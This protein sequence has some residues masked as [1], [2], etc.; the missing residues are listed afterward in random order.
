MPNFTYLFIK[1]YQI[2]KFIF[3][4]ITLIISFN[5]NAQQTISVS[6]NIKTAEGKPLNKAS[7]SLYYYGIKDTLKTVTNEKG[8][9]VFNKVPTKNVS[10]AVSFIGYK[11][12]VDN[13]DL[14]KANGDVVN[15]EVI[16][17]N[18]DYT[19]ET[20]TIESSKI[21][22]K[23]D[24]VSY[25][26]DSTMFRKNDNVEEVLKKLKADDRTKNIPV[27]VFSSS[28]EDPDVKE[29]YA[30]GVNSYVIK[31]LDFDAFFKA[32]TNMGLYWSLLNVV[33]E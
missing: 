4:L 27:V 30:L 21:Q 10:I 20:V 11:K 14:A 24:T 32:V 23:E 3:T 26:V 6:G 5:I 31:P 8:N 28:Q 7:V 9:Y 19:L 12:F 16:M 18:G 29:S 17:T 2:M 22:I 33:P 25:K 1:Q 13:Y 15:N